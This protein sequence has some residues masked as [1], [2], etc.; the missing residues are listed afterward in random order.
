ME[1]LFT[2]TAQLADRVITESIPQLQCNY[3]FAN[4]VEAMSLP[5]TAVIAE[6]A[7][8]HP[9]L[10]IEGQSSSVLVVP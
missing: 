7:D 3:K 6:Q 4:F 10:G 1:A 8:H 2:T 9:S 5:T